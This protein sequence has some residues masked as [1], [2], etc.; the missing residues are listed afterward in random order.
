MALVL[1]LDLG[2]AV[3]VDAGGADLV[4]RRC[5]TLP[6][7][8][9]RIDSTSDALAGAVDAVDADEAGGQLG[10]SSSSLEDPVVA[11][12]AGG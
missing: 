3:G 8:V 9:Q 1:E 10:R 6:K 7:S 12:V 11:E 5:A 4:L 2:D